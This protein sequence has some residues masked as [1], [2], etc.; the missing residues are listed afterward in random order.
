M[1]RLLG[2]TAVLGLSACSGQFGP[3]ASG[4]QVPTP[5]IISPQVVQPQIVM[6]PQTPI[7]LIAL[8]GITV[9]GLI[10]LAGFSILCS[11]SPRPMYLDEHAPRYLE[12]PYPSTKYPIVR[13]PEQRII[14]LH[15]AEGDDQW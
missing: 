14:D 13:A 2:A 12:L 8:L 1:K 3:E 9:V 10:V 4:L 5:V 11:R 7:W 15:G 6:V